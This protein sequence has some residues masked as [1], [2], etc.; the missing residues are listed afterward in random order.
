MKYNEALDYLLAIPMFQNVGSEAYNPSLDT[1]EKLCHEIGDVHRKFRSVHVAG[2]NGKG[3]VTHLIASV[4]GE[5]GYKVGLYTSPHLLDFRERIKVSSEMISEDGVCEFV[6]SYKS[7]LDQLKPSFFEVTTA[8]AFWWFARQKVDVAVVEAGL[9]GR[10]DA[11]NIIRPMVSVITNVSKDHCAILGDTIEKIAVEKSGIIK[12]RVP[13]VL[14][15]WDQQSAMVIIMKAKQMGSESFIASQRYKPLHSEVFDDCQAI[16]YH[17]LLTDEQIEIKTDLKGLYQQKNIATALTTLDI[18]N[19]TT[20]INITLPNVMR[21]F[22]QSHL[23]A[24]WQILG[25]KPTIICDTG[26]NEAGIGYVTKQLA[27]LTYKKLY[28]VIGFVSDKD[29]VTILNLLPKDANYIFT[30]SSVARALPEDKLRDMASA[31]ALVGTT[32]ANVTEAVKMAREM[33]DKDDVIY[34]G[35]STFTV[36]DAL[37]SFS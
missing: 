22:M 19:E 37:K 4:L 6:D 24:R 28:M 33:A 35:G 26:H 27:A 21:G 5:A 3:S 13:V 20:D 2:T 32:A 14:G 34:I 1:I 16:T 23:M 9:G 10:L 36:A 25:E 7:L 8:M 30:K 17:S 29:I 31:A 12:E 15:E 11:T 18:L